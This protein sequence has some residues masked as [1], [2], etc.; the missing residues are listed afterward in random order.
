[1]DARYGELDARYDKLDARY[2]ELEARYGESSKQP[3]G[4]MAST[5]VVLLLAFPLRA[6]AFYLID[7]RRN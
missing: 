2:S 3:H 1:M 6:H 5:Y 4:N 7:R